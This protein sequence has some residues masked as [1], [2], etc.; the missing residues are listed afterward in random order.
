MPRKIEIFIN[1][2]ESSEDPFWIKVAEKLN[3]KGYEV[4]KES[5]PCDIALIMNAS[6]LNP[7]AYDKKIGFYLDMPKNYHGKQVFWMT[8]IMAPI[9]AR[10]YDDDKLINLFGF[11]SERACDEIIN[12]YR[13]LSDHDYN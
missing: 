7:S 5:K 11:T 1:K 4:H 13:Y 8:H 10:Y 3:E 6:F 12:Y 9:L 2:Y